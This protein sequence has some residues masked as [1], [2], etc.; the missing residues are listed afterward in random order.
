MTILDTILDVIFPVNC[1]SCKKRGS[2]LCVD[3][4]LS[5]PSAERESA[6]WIF[7]LFDY[8]HTA[9]KKSIWLLKYKSKRNLAKIYAEVL[10]GKII[11]ELSELRMMSNFTEPILIPIPLSKKRQRERGY[12]Q[13]ELICLEL[14]KIDKE[15]NNFKL[16]KNILIK[17]KE[18]EHQ[19][20]IKD[21]HNR[22]KNLTDSFSVTN[23]E[24]IKNKNIILIDDVLTTGATLSEAKKT[25][26][27]FG[28]RKIIA[29]TLAH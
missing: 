10:Y 24:M 9:I 14:I 27:S 23:R 18:T 8:R 12:N 16:W 25:L 6:T 21:R 17:T 11:E 1:I 20:N 3:C 2:N 26:K 15:K 28:A 13:A 4:L 22:L 19:A 7:P 29:F 5:S